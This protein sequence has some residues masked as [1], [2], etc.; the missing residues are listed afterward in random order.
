MKFSNKTIIILSGILISVTL[1]PY[2]SNVIFENL[3]NYQVKSNGRKIL[4]IYTGG[5]I[6]MEESPQGYVPKKHFLQK[7]L[8]S[9]LDMYPKGQKKG[10]ADYDIIEMNPLLD[11]SNMTPKDWNKIIERIQNNYGKYD[12]FIVVHGTDT[13]AYSSSAVSFAFQNLTKPIIFT[14]SQIPL[15]RLRNDGDNNL[16]TSM[17]LASNFNIP[18]VMLVFNNQIL[19]GNRAK[20]VSSNKLN[21]FQSPNYPQLGAFGYDKM[22]RI[23]STLIQ[24]NNFGFTNANKYDTD[25]KVVVIWLT[26][27]I[28]F[29]TFKS[30]FIADSNIKGVILLTYGI[31]DG[32]VN[33]KDFIGFLNFLKERDIIVINTSQCLEGKVDQG[34]YRTGSMLRSHGVVSGVDMTTEAAYCKLLYLLTIYG[35][36]TSM[37]RTTMKDDI[38]GELSLK[39]S[40]K[41]FSIFN[42]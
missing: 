22:P 26:P 15:A 3:Q 2:L 7:K 27:G 19:R 33:N 24:N 4:L 16:I 25:K 42:L 23:D 31:G 35:S 30:L 39:G 21:A 32:P 36:N 6:G 40:E 8:K 14:G 10:I 29:D 18:E 34:D 11:S 9:F 12:A 20:K 38:R 13:M 28:D 17:V 1:I 37:I 5:T 41:E